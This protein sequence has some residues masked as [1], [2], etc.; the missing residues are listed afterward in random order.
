M[1]LILKPE[2]IDEV[3]IE[4][5]LKEKRGRKEVV[6]I[7][8][9]NYK[10]END[11]SYF[12]D[13]EIK[14]LIVQTRKVFYKFVYTLLFETGARIE[15]ARAVRFRDVDLLNNKIRLIT[16]KQRSEGDVVRYIPISNELKAVL[17]H[18]KVDNE[19]SNDDFLLTQKTNKAPVSRQGITVQLK[20]DCLESL[21][22]VSNINLHRFRHSRAIFLL[23]HGVNLVQVQRLLGHS[24]I[25]NTIIY[26][27]YA[28]RD[29]ENAIHSATNEFYK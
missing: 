23:N 17:L 7:K 24:D 9:K 5:H 22:I 18:H 15:E 25:R 26:L 27:R 20:K 29:F 6:V 1:D 19:L 10:K 14:K 21:G 12:N 28:D 13:A 3:D 2:I 8:K 16:L 11:V 4:E